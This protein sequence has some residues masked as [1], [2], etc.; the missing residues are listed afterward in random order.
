[1]ET[2]SCFGEAMKNDTFV[3]ITW[4]Y[5]QRHKY[6]SSRVNA[7]WASRHPG[8]CLEDGASGWNRHLLNSAPA[9]PT[10]FWWRTKWTHW[11]NLGTDCVT[12]LMIS[13]S[14]FIIVSSTFDVRT[15][16]SSSPLFSLKQP[17]EPPG[18]PHLF[19]QFIES[20]PSYKSVSRKRNV[21]GVETNNTGCGQ[22]STSTW[23]SKVPMCAPCRLPKGL[24]RGVRGL[25]GS[26][27]AP[28]WSSSRDKS[29]EKPLLRTEN[30]NSNLTFRNCTT[31]SSF[32]SL[33]LPPAT[34][35]LATAKGSCDSASSS[36]GE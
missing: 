29:G 3:L 4:L 28:G 23:R 9:T 17:Y 13:S 5:F 18:F 7:L 27:R 1:M 36:L 16:L 35:T 30:L 34:H 24:G 32:T 25:V 31:L 20:L 10:P 6:T 8:L 15:I 11:S 26:G 12:V 22:G 33:V 2:V 14:F 19:T 21:P